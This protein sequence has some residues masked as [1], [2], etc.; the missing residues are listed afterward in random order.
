M[1]E[2]N[3]NATVRAVG[4]QNA[5]YILC[6]QSITLWQIY[7]ELRWG[8]YHPRVIILNP[9]VQLSPWYIKMLILTQGQIKLHKGSLKM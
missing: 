9:R 4:S 1:H 5:N 8:N 2:P 3:Q 7:G 6:A